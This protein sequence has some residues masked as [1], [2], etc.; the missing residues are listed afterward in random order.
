MTNVNI[1]TKEQRKAYVDGWKNSGLSQRE[2][3]SLNG[4]KATTLNTWVK[5][6]KESKE[7][8]LVLIKKK[9]PV[10]LH[11]ISVEYM[12]AKIKA[13]EKTLSTIL[14]TIKNISGRNQ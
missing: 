10:V 4:L 2:Y 11:N 14:M 13:D 1:Y 7:K 8:S 9:S 6:S 3:S 5:R 12:G